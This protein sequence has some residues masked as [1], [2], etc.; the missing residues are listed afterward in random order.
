MTYRLD[1]ITIVAADLDEG[2]RH[3]AAALDL[4]VPAG[5]KHVQMGT[6]NRLMRLGEGIFLEIVAPDPAADPPGRARWFGL[7]APGSTRLATWVAGVPDLDTAVARYPVAGKAEPITRGALNWRISVPQD[8]SLPMDGAFPTF[9]EWPPGPHPSDS[10]PD[11]G[12]RLSVLRIGHPDV[13]PIAS[14]AADYLKDDRLVFAESPG[15]GLVAEI[16]T[17]SGRRLLV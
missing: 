2:V 10:M 6:H 12:C 15:A 5:G 4:E 11:L 13:A 17:P 9:I 7:D 8:G 14:F 3:V 1:H 16:D